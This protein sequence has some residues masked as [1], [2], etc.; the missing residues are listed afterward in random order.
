MKEESAQDGPG[1]YDDEATMVRAMTGATQG[2]GIIVAGGNRGTGFSV[3]GSEDFIKSLPDILE[4]MA[5][6]IRAQQREQ[7]LR[8]RKT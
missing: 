5:R 6:A 7:A 4:I 2:V 1:K 3:Q 8:E